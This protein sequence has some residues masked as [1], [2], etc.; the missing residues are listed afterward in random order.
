MGFDIV[1][2]SNAIR[3]WFVDHLENFKDNGPT[4]ITQENFED[5]IHAMESVIRDGGLTDFYIDYK[6]FNKQVE[7]GENEDTRRDDWIKIFDSWERFVKNG[8]R[9]YEQFCKVANEKFPSSS[10][11]FGDPKYN[12]WYIKDL[13]TN[14][15]RFK[16]IYNKI[17]WDKDEIDYWEEY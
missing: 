5:I 7:S 2:T 17:D 13:F 3:K 11:L 1:I 16:E 6:N 12:A 10:G 8:G 14:L 4:P 9:K 15:E